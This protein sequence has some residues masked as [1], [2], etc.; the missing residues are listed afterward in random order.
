[1]HIFEKFAKV[2]WKYTYRRLLHKPIMEKFATH[3]FRE[4]NQ[5]F[6]SRL[7]PNLKVTVSPQAFKGSLL[8][9]LDQKEPLMVLKLLKTQ[10][11]Q[12]SFSYTAAADGTEQSFIKGLRRL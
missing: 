6:W 3:H 12:N 2:G 10:L 5:K 9:L 1:M 11:L 7:P 4:R 8:L